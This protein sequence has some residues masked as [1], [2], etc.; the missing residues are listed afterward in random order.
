MTVGYEVLGGGARKV[1]VLHGWFGDHTMLAPMQR[2]LDTDAFTFATIAYRGYGVSK[3]QRGEYTMR[4]IAADTLAVADEL[5]W[6]RFSAIGHSMG[7]KVAQRLLADAPGRIERIVALTPV[8]AAAVPFDEATW[9]LFSGAAASLDNRRAIINIS[10]GGRLDPVWV[11]RMARYSQETST[12]EAFGAYVA[13]WAKEDFHHEIKGSQV[14]MKVVVG[15]HDPSLNAEVMRATMLQWFPRAELEVL[16][17][18][19][20]Y[21][22]DEAPI[23]VA[24][25]IQAFLRN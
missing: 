4:E 2:A 23:A 17:N 5:G 10:T 12:E 9:A 15:E 19:G 24:T 18:A 22:I 13:A 8:P 6:D 7:G 1:I 20:H 16:P 21:P 25:N 11:E 14:R 3:A